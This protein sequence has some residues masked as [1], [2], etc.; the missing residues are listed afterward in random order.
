MKE[1]AR[2]LLQQIYTKYLSTG[3]NG[4]YLYGSILRDD[5]DPETSDIDGIAIVDD[6]VPLELREKILSELTAAMPELKKIGFQLLYKS[7][8]NGGEPKGRIAKVI[9]PKALLLEM[10]YWE[11]VAGK[12]FLPKDFPPT[13]F[14]EAVADE[15]RIAVSRG[16][17]DVKN[18]EEE[19]YE[20]FTKLLIYILYLQDEEVN[21][22]KPFSYD[23]IRKLQIPLSEA[24]LETK[25]AQY[26]KT[27]FQKNIPIF[28]KFIDQLL[29]N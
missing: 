29:S 8:L 24:L 27:V 15:M 1:K 3:E 16:W 14:S 2:K 17:S 26:N 6:N 12:I 4:V 13:N 11:H 22:A 28:Q 23:I 10:P 21:G 9:S 19:K 18:V 5:F 7:E 20:F 25:A